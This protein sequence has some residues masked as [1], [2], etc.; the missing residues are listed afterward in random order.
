MLLQR[1]QLLHPHSPK[2][3]LPAALRRDRKPQMRSRALLPSSL[4]L[5][6]KFSVTLASRAYHS[7]I[8]IIDLN[9][10]LLNS[11]PYWLK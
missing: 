10:L 9:G 5:Q 4:H 3:L 7:I 11:F 8:Q 1:R 6:G 2:T